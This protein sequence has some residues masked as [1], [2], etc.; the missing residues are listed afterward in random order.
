MRGKGGAW[1]VQLGLEVLGAMAEVHNKLR[2][3]ALRMPAGLNG[4]GHGGALCDV[5]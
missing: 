4:L 5:T 1:A 3:P 2:N